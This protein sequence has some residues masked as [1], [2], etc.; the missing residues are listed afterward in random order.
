MRRSS[1]GGLSGMVDGLNKVRTL[2]RETAAKLQRS[3]CFG[4]GDSRPIQL[5]R[6][7][8]VGFQAAAAAVY[9]MTHCG[10]MG[11]CALLLNHHT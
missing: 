11:I 4:N 8:C 7:D 5:I 2:I 1:K 9:K 3:N 6:H 10:F